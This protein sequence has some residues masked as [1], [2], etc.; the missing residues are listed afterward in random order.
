[1]LAVGRLS[2]EK[3]FDLL[4][5]ALVTV[6]EN[7]P[8]ADLVI[9]GAGPEQAALQAQCHKLGLSSAVRFVGYAD[10]PQQ[11]FPDASL[12]VSSSRH[13]GLPNALLEAAAG[14]LPIVAL[15]ASTGLSDLLRSQPGVWLA[16]EVSSE[17][18]ASSLLSALKALR[19]NERFEHAFIQQF[20][21]DRAIR[22]YE[23]LIESVLQE[24]VSEHI[25]ERV[26]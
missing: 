6:R 11:Y 13:E 23:E 7:H 5:D 18:L 16:N 24:R 21:M 12:F 4:L 3:G 20:R 26:C 22:A 19:P 17:A 10:H 1:L 8:T 9:A 2:R 15:P 25:Q 14:G